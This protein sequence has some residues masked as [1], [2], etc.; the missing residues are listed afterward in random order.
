MTSVRFAVLGTPQPQG[1]AKAFIPKGWSRAIITSDNKKLKPWRQDA[2]QQALEA[3]DGVKPVKCAV[4][5]YVTFHFARPKS[6]PKRVVH[7]TTKS[8]VDKLARGIL[9]S[10]TGTVFE[11]DSQVIALMATKQFGLPERAEVMVEC[12]DEIQQASQLAS[13]NESYPL[14]QD[15]NA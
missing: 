15:I 12:V 13:F 10:L 3:M 8:D 7:K 14:F 5:V 2:A 11:D 9:D 6:L 1:S 4:V